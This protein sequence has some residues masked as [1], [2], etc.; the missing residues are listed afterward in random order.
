MA[1]TVYKVHRESQRDGILEAAEDLFIEKG[2]RQVTINKIAAASRLTRATVYK[3]FGSKDEIA[4]EIFKNITAGWVERDARDVWS[5]EGTGFELIERF[6]LSQ[7]NY[8][9]ANRREA[10]FF[11]E[12]NYLYAKDLSSEAAI[13]IFAASIEGERTKLLQSIHRGQQDGSLRTDMVPE[14]LLAIL[15]NFTSGMMDRIGELGD[16]VEAEYG[17]NEQDVFSNLFQ[18]FLDGLKSRNRNN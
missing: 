10:R 12:F 2:I 9:F 6:A 14:M 7:L 15:L 16:K 4:S 18:A 8:I 5:T 13:Q 17:L 11:V 1:T 3:Y